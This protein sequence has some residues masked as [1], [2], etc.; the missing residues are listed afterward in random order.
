MSARGLCRHCLP[1]RQSGRI[2]PPR[3]RS[4]LCFAPRC[5]RS[6]RRGRSR[7]SRC[8]P[9]I[10]QRDRGADVTACSRDKCNASDQFIRRLSLRFRASNATVPDY[11]RDTLPFLP[12]NPQAG[13][14]RYLFDRAL[15]QLYGAHLEL[16]HLWQIQP[17]HHEQKRTKCG[18]RIARLIQFACSVQLMSE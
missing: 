8:L 15:L 4:S 16:Q 17:R 18:E 3:A 14:G 5:A 10:V 7:G 9:H 1:A 2:A 11:A 12:G 6:R 13:G